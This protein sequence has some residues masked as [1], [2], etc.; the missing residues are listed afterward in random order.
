MKLDFVQVKKMEFDANT[1][2]LKLIRDGFRALFSEYQI[3]KHTSDEMVIALNEA[4]MNIIQHAYKGQIGKIE[5]DIKKNA[6]QWRFE[7]ID[8]APL[9][10]INA[11]KAKDLAEVRPGGLGVNFLK[12][13]MDSVVYEN[14]QNSQQQGNKLTLTKQ[15]S[16]S[17]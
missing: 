12:K 2:N 14:I 7:L 11:I 3:A 1:E 10:D 17:D 6:N 5:I 9:V 13:I 16:T 8:F 15:I 4:C